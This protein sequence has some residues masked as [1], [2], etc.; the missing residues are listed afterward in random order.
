VRI[1]VEICKEGARFPE[2]A[3][4]GDSGLD[5]YALNDYTIHPQETLIIPTG[6]K[7]A[8]PKGYEIQIRPRSG[9]SS[10]TTLRVANSPATIDSG[11]RKEIGV[12]I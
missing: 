1:P 3:H 10:S 5:I 4:E 8:I 2:Y 6:I 11:Y 9:L 7:C 12:I